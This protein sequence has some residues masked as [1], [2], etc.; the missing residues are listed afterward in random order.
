MLSFFSANWIIKSQPP[1]S[2]CPVSPYDE[3]FAGCKMATQR[4]F[5]VGLKVLDKAKVLHQIARRSVYHMLDFAK[6]M[7][8]TYLTAF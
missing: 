3:V 5:G 4:G 2:P 1:I 7:L 6:Q 8:D